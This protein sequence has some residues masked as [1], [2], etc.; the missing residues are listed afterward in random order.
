MIGGLAAAGLLAWGG[1][2]L[3]AALALGAALTIRRRRRGSCCAPGTS[4]NASD[5]KARR[6]RSAGR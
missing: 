3:A 1:I 4:Q 5:A 6:A 2:G